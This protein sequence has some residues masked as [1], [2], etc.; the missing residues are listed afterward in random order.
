MYVHK[1][2]VLLY[3][4]KTIFTAEIPLEKVSSTF[5]TFSFTSYKVKFICTYIN[6]LIY[7]HLLRGG[8]GCRFDQPSLE[9]LCSLFSKIRL[10]LAYIPLYMTDAYLHMYLLNMAGAYLSPDYD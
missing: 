3:S 9:D 4:V 1:T 10:L 5:I 2:S 7:K 8:W 6:I